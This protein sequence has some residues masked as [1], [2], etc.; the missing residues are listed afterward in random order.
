MA[1]G[2]LAKS[3][4]PMVSEITSTPAARMARAR[5]VIAIVAAIGTR[6]WRVE[7]VGMGR[8]TRRVGETHHRRDRVVVGCTH[9]AADH[10]SASQN[11]WM[12]VQA[13]RSASVL[14]A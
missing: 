9:P 7:R 6:A 11:R 4:S 14:V 8:L 2:G 13:S 1:C 12:R 10:V 3:G 5:D